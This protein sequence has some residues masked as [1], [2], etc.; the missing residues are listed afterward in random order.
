[1]IK[2]ANKG[3]IKWSYDYEDKSVA[4]LST[5]TFFYGACISCTSLSCN[6][7]LIILNIAFKLEGPLYRRTIRR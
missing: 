7:D 5:A 2:T 3:I 1:M 4:N 6:S